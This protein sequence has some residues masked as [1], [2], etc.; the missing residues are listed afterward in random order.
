MLVADA[1]AMPAAQMFVAAQVEPQ[2]KSEVGRVLAEALEAGADS[3]DALLSSLPGNGHGRGAAL[4]A[5]ASHGPAVIGEHP[6]AA[7]FAHHALALDVLAEA[8][9]PA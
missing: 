2:A 7:A 3:I 5:L 1:V 6:F 4:E 9:P 8:A